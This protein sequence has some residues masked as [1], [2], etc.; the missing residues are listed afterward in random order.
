MQITI[1]VKGWGHLRPRKDIICIIL[2][3]VWRMELIL[4]IEYDLKDRIF[5]DLT[6]IN[7]VYI[8]TKK[9][10]QKYWLCKCSCGEE[11][12]STTYE[13]LSGKSKRCVKCSNRL[14][15][16]SLTKNID[17]KKFG[18]LTVIRS[19]F[20]E[21]KPQVECICDCGNKVILNR[22]DVITNHTKSCGCLQKEKASTARK[23]DWH[24]VISDYGIKFVNEYSVNN[25]GQSIWE[26]TCG[27]CGNTF[28]DIP[29]RIMNGHVTSCGC[30]KRSSKE[31]FIE[32][33]LIYNNIPY[34]RQYSFDNCIYKYKLK[35]DFVIFKNDE[36]FY[37]I[38]YD[39][40]QHFIPIDYYGG[41]AQYDIRKKRD[42]IKNEYCKRN[43]INLLRLPYT[44]TDDEIKDKIIHIMNP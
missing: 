24:G 26:C 40:M 14:R 35:F 27:L 41:T 33:I 29:T 28:Y 31:Q 6:V 43:N 32:K 36:V 38:E 11:K 44:L 23:R 18:R 16:A 21:S 9:K 42:D 22:H 5:E 20:D 8:D 4:S 13:L 15:R 30:R 12:I 3:L 19:L 37:L 10:N 1:S 39:G 7:R 17:G 34:K 2:I 25:N